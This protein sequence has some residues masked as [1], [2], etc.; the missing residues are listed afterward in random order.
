MINLSGR[1]LKIA[2]MVDK[3]NVVADI[4]TDHA[5]IPI[6]LLQAGICKK[7]VATD[8][9]RAPLLKAE[10][11]INKYNLAEGIELRPGEG[12]EPIGEDEC[13]VIVMAGIGGYLISEIL[14]AS[15][16]KARKAKSIIMQPMYTD[17][18]LREY[19]LTKG[20]NITNEVLVRDGRRIYVIIKAAYDGI[21]RKEPSLFCHIGRPLFDNR[22]PLLK[23]H[24]ERKIRI[25]A[26]IVKGL[27]KS[28]VSGGD[29]HKKEEEI[30]LQL[31]NAYKKYYDNQ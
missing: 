2:Q 22:D 15:F 11:N 30:L 12:M 28:G 13:D 31:Q 20:F 29:K 23:T 21:R 19:L 5:Y 18:V 27:H 4:G 8:I 3:C 26:K 17:E 16:N 25:Q 10:R 14:E 1:L 6:Y 7:A 9:S 24:L